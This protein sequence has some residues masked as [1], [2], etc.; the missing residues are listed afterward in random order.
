MGD[1]IIPIRKREVIGEAGGLVDRCRFTLG[2]YGDDL[3]PDEISSLLG[4]APTSAHRR[5]DAR[6]SGGQW[7]KGAWLHSVEGTS[8]T[9]PEDLVHLLLAR[10]PTD[11]G[12]W[13]TLRARY[14]VHLGFGIFTERWNREFDLSGEAL[15]RIQVIGVG[16]DFDIYADSES[17]DDG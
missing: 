3:V 12:L 6:R 10:L 8:P 15:R 7:P 1:D 16:V 17:T 13:T 4:C 11:E 9:G 14:R 5:G 2:V